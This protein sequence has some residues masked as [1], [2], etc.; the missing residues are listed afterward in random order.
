MNRRRQK[1]KKNAELH[2][3][4]QQKVS[5]SIEEVKKQRKLQKEK[6]KK[7]QK[8]YGKITFDRYSEAVKNLAEASLKKPDD[9]NREK[10]IV[11]LY[12]KQNPT[13]TE[14]QLDLEVLDGDLSDDDLTD[15]ETQ[16]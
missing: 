10:N 4:V 9:I 7:L 2:N 14:K 16:N 11:E 8:K 1:N 5:S 6:L 15:I 3:A 12:L 13:A